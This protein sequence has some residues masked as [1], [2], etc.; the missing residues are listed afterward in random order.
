MQT[1]NGCSA[2]LKFDLYGQQLKGKGLFFGHK[3]PGFCKAW[4]HKAA[5]SRAVRESKALAS[6]LGFSFGKNTQGRKFLL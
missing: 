6:S 5:G 4:L 3:L 1:G 2:W